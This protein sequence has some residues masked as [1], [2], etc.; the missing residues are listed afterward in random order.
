M[1]I[2]SLSRICVAQDGRIKANFDDNTIM[3]VNAG[4][5]AFISC[6][7]SATG[8]NPGL[9]QLSEY[10]LSRHVNELSVVL[11]F[12][13]MHVDQPF[14]C[15]P[16]LRAAATRQGL[17]LG[18]QLAEVWWADNAR[19]AVES[20]MVETFPDGRV[21]MAAVDGSA[22]IVLHGHRR[23]FAVCYPLLVEDRPQDGKYD[24]VWQT[25]VFSLQGYPPR[26]HAA[27][28]LLQAVVVLL[29][30]QHAEL[31]QQRQEKHEVPHDDIS[32]IQGT[33][34]LTVLGRQR[35]QRCSTALP[36][37]TDR[38]LGGVCD[39]FQPGSWWYEP[40]LTLFPTDEVI[41]MEWQPEATY[42]FH[43]SSGEVEVWVHVDESCLASIKQGR[44]VTH[45]RA[46]SDTYSVTE[47]MYAAACV[48]EAVWLQPPSASPEQ[49][50]VATHAPARYPLGQLAAHALKLR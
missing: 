23:R 7:M 49:D 3:L 50:T 9:R 19:E 24:Y 4:G 15:K 12:R 47:Q 22:R 44:F 28:Q 27:V 35:P 48:P 39:N 17:S 10:A 30:S 20:G 21:S 41:T 11:E 40:T 37:A 14:I 31:G 1:T 16:L 29:D 2:P 43:P 34:Q 8:S 26:W 25:Q 45:L 5:S 13:N 6:P 42:Q 18:Y 38:G 32:S 33:G 36:T 46:Q